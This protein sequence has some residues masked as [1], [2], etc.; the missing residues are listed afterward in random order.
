MLFEILP[1]LTSILPLRADSFG[2]INTLYVIVWSEPVVLFVPSVVPNK[3]SQSISSETDQDKPL[4]ALKIK[5]LSNEAIAGIVL[6]SSTDKADSFWITVISPFGPLDS[7]PTRTIIAPVRSSELGLTGTLKT[8]FW[9]FVVVVP[10][11]WPVKVSQ[12]FGSV[13]A[14]FH[15][16]SE[17]A[18]K[19]EEAS[20]A[21]SALISTGWV[22]QVIVDSAC[23]T[24]IVFFRLAS[25]PISPPSTVMLPVRADAYGLLEAALTFRICSPPVASSPLVARSPD[26][27]LSQPSDKR[28]RQFSPF[29]R[30]N[31]DWPSEPEA[32]S[33]EMA[34]P[35]FMVDPSC[36]ISIFCSSPV[37]F[38]WKENERCCAVGL[39]VSALKTIFAG[40]WWV[41]LAPYP[42]GMLSL[43]NAES[44]FGNLIVHSSPGRAVTCNSVV[45]P[46]PAG[47]GCKP[48]RSIGGIVP[49][50]MRWSVTSIPFNVTLIV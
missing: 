50:V 44:Q 14:V 25:L 42:T 11:V 20:F 4:V 40:P 32:A 47:I 19:N 6:S 18:V 23:D 26:A 35:T 7:S 22:G 46:L 10:V 29:V 1:A 39:A 36:T 15:G 34:L 28:A 43:S 17:V 30:V 48:S 41:I 2:L 27:Q 12:P 9:G 3:V 31:V 13:T 24:E 49:T 21:P 8:T 33:N 37:T 5:V 38:I 16:K 45:P